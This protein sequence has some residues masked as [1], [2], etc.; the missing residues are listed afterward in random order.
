MTVA[1]IKA[2]ITRRFGHCAFKKY[3]DKS[4]YVVTDVPVCDATLKEAFPQLTCRTTSW[5]HRFIVDLPP[6]V[7]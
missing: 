5:V 6:S 3:K 2:A 4:L 7:G 1:D